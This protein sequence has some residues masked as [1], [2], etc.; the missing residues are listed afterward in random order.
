MKKYFIILAVLLSGCA[1]IDSIFGPPVEGR[2]AYCKK[3]PD[4]RTCK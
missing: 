2:E 1:T 3:W 4:D